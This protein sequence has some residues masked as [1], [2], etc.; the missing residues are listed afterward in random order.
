MTTTKD[1]KNEAQAFVLGPFFQTPIPSWNAKWFLEHSAIPSW[2]RFR[3]PTRRIPLRIVSNF[4][5]AHRDEI[6]TS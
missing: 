3:F 4:S 2:N 6:P 1:E 5:S